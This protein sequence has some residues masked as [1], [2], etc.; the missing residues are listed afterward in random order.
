V[1]E[2]R[3]SA[4]QSALEK[5]DQLSLE[6]K[7]MFFEIAYRR[8]IEA[9]RVQLAGEIAESRVAYGRG[10]VS[11]GSLDDLMAELEV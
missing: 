9:R 6:E 4:L 5:V 1:D 10:D 3:T 7:E 8:F 11:R 2:K